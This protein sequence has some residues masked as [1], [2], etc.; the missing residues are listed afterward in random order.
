LVNTEPSN[1]IRRREL[2]AVSNWI[3]G[4]MKSKAN[5]TQM[6]KSLAFSITITQ[7]L[8]LE[9]QFAFAQ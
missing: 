6:Q 9:V 7:V 5:A 2:T 8:L 4:L 3:G 1:S